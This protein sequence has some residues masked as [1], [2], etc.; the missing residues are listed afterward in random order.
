MAA[1][2]TIKI[3]TELDSSKAQ[4]AMK[5]FSG[6][7]K[8][9]LK[10][11]TIAAGTASAAITAMAGYAVKVGADFEAGMSKVSAISG[12]AG[13]DLD[14][15]TEKAKEMG[16][17]TKFSATEAAS[18]FE[19]MAMAGWKTEDM[20][21][22]IEGVMNLAA[23]S[24]ENLATTSDIVTDAITAFGLTSKDSGHFVDVL[25]KASSNSNTNV[26]M[27]G[28]TF[29]YVAPVAG[30]LGFCVDDCAVAIGLMAN[31]GIKA[32]QAGTTLRQIFTNLVKPTDAMQGAMDKLGISLTD[33]EGKTKSLD[34]LMGDLRRSF[35]GLTEAEKANY[36]A[37]LAGQEGMSGFLAIVNASDA[38]FEALKSSIANADGAA[39]DMAETMQDN[40]KGSLTILGSSM[41]GFAI[42][43]YDRVKE[44]LKEA[45]DTG[46]E[47]VN[48]LSSAFDSGGLHGVVDEA[49]EIFSEL[50]DRV[51]ESSDEAEKIVT[52]LRNVASAGS[53]LAKTGIKAAA[54]AFELLATNLDIAVPLLAS[55]V[56]AVKGYTVA[57]TA[58]S[59]ISKLSK[60]Y[61]ASAAALD[62]FIVANG[63]SA[64]ATA[65]STGAITL[66]QIAVGV[67][68]KQLGLAT[69]AHAAFNAV[70]SAN[71]VGLAVTAVA[72]LTAGL[73][74][75]TVVAGDA[76]NKTYELSDSEKET[77]ES[78][79]DLTESLND[80]R[81]ARGE[82]VQSINREYE[83][84]QNLLS[85]LRSI[86]D[87]NG[88]VK[89]GYEERAAFI[90]G[91]L[92]SALGTEIEL[93]DG[94]IQNY[95]ETVGAL[96]EVITKKKA[97]ALCAS[98]EEE[99]ASAYKDSKEA[100]LAYKDATAVMEEKEETLA[101]AQKN[102]NEVT[103]MYGNNSGP[104]AMG[105]ISEAK[106]AVSEAENA[107][108]EAATAVDEASTSL[109]SL[110]AEVNNYN[111]LMEAMQS[112]TVEEIESA[113][114]ALLSGYQGYTA[115]MLA[116]SETAKASMLEQASQMTGSLSVL[117]SEGGQM[118]Q[119]FGEEAANSAA[120]SVSE[121]Q[122]LPGGIKEAIDSIGTDGAGAMVAAL[123]QA[124]LDGKLS[125][126]SKASYEAFMNG[127]ADLPQETQNILSG[128]VE[129]AME[130]LEG[131]DQIQDK[132]EENGT[133]F[134]EA[135][136][137]VLQINSPSKKVMEIFEGVWEGA[138]DGLDVGGADL[139]TKGTEVCNSFLDTLRNSGLGEAMMGIGANIMSFF[140]IGVA[141]Q[142]GQSLIAGQGNAE[143]ARTGAGSV[144]P[145][146]TG[147]RFGGMLGTGVAGT[148]GTLLQKGKEIADRAKTGAGGVNPTSTGGKFGTQ[149]ATGVVSQF[150]NSRGK[151]KG[152]ADNAKSGAA[153]ISA[154]NTG[155][156][157]G[158]GF[159]G[160]IRNA[161]GNAVS[162]A[163][164][165]ASRALEAIK[166]KLD[167]HSP[168]KETAKLGKWFSKGLGV[169]IESEGKMVEESAKNI[170]QTALD[171]LNL[172]TIDLDGLAEKL[173]DI[174]IPETMMRVNMAVESRQEAV[175]DKV[176]RGHVVADRMN[177]LFQDNQQSF[178]LSDADA[179]K[180][181]RI[182]AERA[183]P[184]MVKS[185][186]KS[187]IRMEMYGEK[188]GSLISPSVD[189][190]LAVASMKSRRY[191]N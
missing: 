186:E 156:N 106:Q 25:A 166:S 125:E 152:L 57:K 59:V 104:K 20:L 71:P 150:L 51:A 69:A 58:A 124:D 187:G 117:V 83:G 96:D 34:T 95:Q 163:A 116:T 173:K 100:L 75:Y 70:V 19:Y 139:N 98:L 56:T 123:A 165:L 161:I 185:L 153:S 30:A 115:E 90:T 182:F 111:A 107:F 146:G 11:I 102:L 176:I 127:L 6:T 171:A 162:A 13:S 38:D 27:M 112:G 179:Q 151:G 64:V 140:G 129:G 72:A 119:A 24:G 114:S 126:E 113:M 10:G 31:S 50:A 170:S 42:K 191:M 39:E 103:D 92:S 99:M 36:A 28:E 178:S 2:G 134:L 157:F 65:A 54:K 3:N 190:N 5:K 136:R 52:P 172:D 78:C 4:S 97:A 26:G 77:L 145:T 143:A 138:S 68:T 142:Q 85:E 154:Q 23:A 67:F 94:V 21:D 169:G 130:G 110:S 29:K 175:A 32:S 180:I 148:A 41:E 45:A 14:R 128:A 88:N 189:S 101:E 120:K 160:G 118:Y 43:V 17:K 155:Y 15:L 37:T 79:N 89:A 147:A 61:T 84:Y 53:S 121:F 48:R 159:A 105:A 141:S 188:V 16:G 181:G 177:S 164:S 86:T 63:T 158:S 9:A 108:N 7:A 174:D 60:A 40:L 184:I 80:Q 81:T 109:N 122:K 55:G 8:S 131:F 47:C 73:V 76:K 62:L 87:E 18:A 74:A 168:S 132:A 46:T 133:S 82:N 1:D 22:G 144:D 44:P 93:T 183:A 91:E 33:S 167:I 35:S 66:K 137:E 149:Y 135:L 49:G 12:A